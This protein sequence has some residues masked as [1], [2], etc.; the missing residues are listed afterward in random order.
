LLLIA[1][2]ALP[3][4][5][6]LA[7]KEELW[8]RAEELFHAALELPPEARQAFLDKTCSKDAE[9]RRQV[10]MLISK[11]EQAGSF[12]DKPALADVTASLDGSIAMIGKAISHYK[13]A[14]K[15]GE[16][17]MGVVYLAHDTSLDRK[18]AVKFL[19]DF[20][21]HDETARKRFVREARSAA[22]LDHPFICA[23]H[24]VGEA[25][26]KSFIVMEY[27]EGQTIRDRMTQ[28]SVPLKQAMLWAVEIAEALAV[29]HEKGIIHRD[30]KPANIMLLR[31]GHTKVMDFGLAKQ[32]SGTEQFGSQETTLTGLTREGT[33]VGTLPYMSPEQ[34]QGKTVDL[35]SDLFSFGIVI[36]EMLTGINPFKRDSGFD[37]AE[38]ILR[39]VPAP[40]SNYRKDAPQSLVALINKLLAK[41]AKDRY[42]QAREVADNLIKILD[43][44]FGQQI[45][46]TPP[47]FVR[48]RKALK[49][50]VYLIP[51][52]LVLAAAA[53]FSVQGLRSYQKAKWAREK[54]LP[55]IEQLV[56]NIS[57]SGEGPNSWAA[58]D[59]AI[60]AERYIPDDPLLQRLM[61]SICRNVKL[62][63]NP[64]GA[65]VY[66][67][68]YSDT[69]S[70][71]RYLGQTPADGV[72][73]PIGFSRIKLEKEGF[74]TVNDIKWVPFF[75]DT[76]PYVLS[77]AGSIPED[78]ELLP[79]IAYPAAYSGLHMP[80]LEHLASES[81][82]DFLM[83][84]YEVTNR[85]FK[86]FVDNGGYTN[87]QL[88]KQPFIK[89][90][91][92]LSW[93]D[94]M[95]LFKDKTGQPGPATW[96][97]RDYPKGQDDN[98]VAGVCW[99]EAAAYAEFVGKRLPTIYHWDRAAFTYASP[100]IVPLSNLDGKGPRPVGTSQSMNRFG[101][102]DLAGNVREWCFN[103]STRREQRFILG[104]GWNDPPYAF[105]DAIAQSAFDRSATNGFRCIK[106]SG[107]EPNQAN[108]QKI[109]ELPFRDFLTEP[110]VS[111]ETF[112]SFLKLHAYDKTALNAKV[113][114][115]KEEEGSIREKITY[116]AA[117]GNERMMGYLFLPK[118]GKPP[119]Q[120]VIFFP[121]S[122]VMFTRSSESLKAPA[123]FLLKSGRAIMFP[124]YKS[125][126]E[127]GDGLATDYPNETI[128]YRDH[129][130]MWSK[131]L[132]RSIDYLETRKDIDADKIAY[133]GLSWGGAN[134]AIMLAVEPRIKT[135]VLVIAGLFF[136]RSLP[137]VDQLHYLRHIK[138][139]VLMLNGKYDF[140]VPYGTSQLPFYQL[141]GTP[142]DNKKLLVY[143]GGHNVPRIEGMKETL[144][145]L[146]RYLGP[147]AQ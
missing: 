4:G 1:V 104:G 115:I 107:S 72:R 143:E 141:L 145:W 15:I 38:A 51:L 66:V 54:L 111:D 27:L 73:L 126:Y 87:P 34:V 83:D 92:P 96:E 2:Y 131:D 120:L 142:K 70:H 58:Y 77:K 78:M 5:R 57:T 79:K 45:I 23:I 90:G 67:K 64:P 85:A 71:W 74:R 130:I 86:R 129:V 140:Y 39:D 125:T 10:D 42:Q 102:F 33:T 106:Y 136:Q 7:M 89:N 84:R 80:G 76:L 95:A 118:K 68:P 108:L 25:E 60:Q 61:Q 69:G 44:T 117:Y 24:E 17:G 113:E 134:G 37:T 62:S 116:N 30:L 29:A 32:V 88:W 63:S 100:E 144:A 13:I 65:K 47:A 35:R 31:T 20:L 12:L 40:I 109:I 123:D 56:Q 99:Y 8:R 101:I 53:Y 19:P 112:A 82:S 137:E 22:A 132:R 138:S 18:V 41:D 135:S 119:F 21:K 139:P 97:V 46:I 50:P 43:N 14:E 52:I 49:K 6:R 146:D 114:S 93:K 26:G 103:E 98:P 9:L 121:G 124:I 128:S 48:L 127:R 91:K 133:F 55:Q 81:V 36:Y 147:V 28:G 11:D 110:Q 3:E 59:L 122:Y 16:G 94:A 105:N 75:W